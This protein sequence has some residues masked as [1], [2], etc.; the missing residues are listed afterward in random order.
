MVLTFRDD[1]TC[2]ALRRDPA[3]D[4]DRP[5]WTTDRHDDAVKPRPGGV[6]IPIIRPFP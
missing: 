1:T 3:L 4:T 2:L 6:A 5:F